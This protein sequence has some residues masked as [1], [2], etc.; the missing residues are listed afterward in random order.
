MASRAAK[1]ACASRFGEISMP[2]RSQ[3]FRQLHLDFHTS[4][5]IPDLAARFDAAEFAAT[6]QRAR[7][8]SV[9]LFARCWH[10]WMYFPSQKF[11]DRVHPHLDG[12]D[13]LAEQI[14]ACHDAGIHAPIYVAA[15]IDWHSAQQHPEWVRLS[16]DGRL[17]KGGVFEPKLGPPLC[18]HGPFRGFLFAHVDEIL[19][20]TCADG[21]WFDGVTPQ[22]CCC[23]FCRETMISRGLDPQNQAHRQSFGTQVA[24][25]FCREMSARVREKSPDATLFYNAGH[26][27]PRHRL[28]RD[29][30]THFEIESLPGGGWGY[31][32]FPVAARLAR[33]FGRE[34]VG[35]TGKF[36]TSW[37]DF[38]EKR[39]GC[40][41]ACGGE[42]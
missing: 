23:R 35:M 39:S 17:G 11:P 10:G 3:P 28:W 40:P 5:H 27:G 32:H 18:L 9:Q 7:V 38:H 13:L 16:P 6:L 31:L 34:I 19:A 8:Q 33:T 4:Q 25:D 26:I 30:H 12:R 37:G 21:F 1:K 2:V 41:A 29:S 36:H 24:G 15:E 22:D 14:A 20:R 42:E